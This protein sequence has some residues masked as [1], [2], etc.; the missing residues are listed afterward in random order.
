LVEVLSILAISAV[1][2]LGDQLDYLTCPITKEAQEQFFCGENYSNPHGLT[3]SSLRNKV[4]DLSSE[5]ARL[6][7]ER[8]DKDRSEPFPVI[9]APAIR[10]PII[11]VGWENQLV[12][13]VRQFGVS[14]AE[15]VAAILEL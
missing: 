11:R 7:A 5:L 9:Y 3:V 6:L 4:T 2:L 14:H 10:W 15:Y 13:E 1:P 12:Y 8:V